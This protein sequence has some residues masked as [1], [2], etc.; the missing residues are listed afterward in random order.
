M[1]QARV[2]MVGRCWSSDVARYI[3]SIFDHTLAKLTV[4]PSERVPVPTGLPRGPV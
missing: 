4:M 2:Q 3:M 1:S